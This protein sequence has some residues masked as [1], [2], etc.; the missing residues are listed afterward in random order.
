SA[1]E[2]W[3]DKQRPPSLPEGAA[4]YGLGPYGEFRDVYQ[5]D[6][7]ADTAGPERRC[8]HLGIDVFVPAGTPVHAPLAGE[9]AS[10]TYNSDPLDYRYTL[11]LRHEMPDGGAFHT[12]Y[13][14]LAASLRDLLAVGA[15]VEA[16]QMIAHL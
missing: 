15:R 14:H 12:L 5:A 1:F 2:D 10:L 16:G 4:F 3:F 8:R 7:F 6:Q 11:I 13:G 9:V